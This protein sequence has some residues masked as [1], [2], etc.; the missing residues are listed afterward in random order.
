LGDEFLIFA[1][2]CDGE[3]AKQIARQILARLSAQGMP[4]VGA[5]FSVSIG[6]T[7]HDGDGADFARLHREADSALHQARAEGRNRI[8]MFEPPAAAALSDPTRKVTANSET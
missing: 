1:P 2:D 4:L 5:A 3:A 7:T 8:A 6:I